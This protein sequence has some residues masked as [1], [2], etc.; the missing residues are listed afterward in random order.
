MVVARLTSAGCGLV[1]AM[2]RGWVCDEAVVR[3]RRVYPGQ[4]PGLPAMPARGVQRLRV[5]GGPAGPWR[6]DANPAA[7]APVREAG[8]LGESQ[9]VW[10]VPA[11]NVARSFASVRTCHVPT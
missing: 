5:K 10:K 9:S 11:V 6:S 4:A 3:M 2:W 8:G 7:C 1:V